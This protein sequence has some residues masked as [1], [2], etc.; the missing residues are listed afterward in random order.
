MLETLKGYLDED[1]AEYGEYAPTLKALKEE[2]TEY[3]AGDTTY[4]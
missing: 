4:I 1:E 2:I 3:L